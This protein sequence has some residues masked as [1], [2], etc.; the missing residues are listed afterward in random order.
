MNPMSRKKRIK[1]NRGIRKK[2]VRGERAAS[3]RAISSERARSGRA[4]TYE[5]ARSSRAV[6]YERAESGRAISSERTRSGR[7]KTHNTNMGI[8]AGIVASMLILAFLYLFVV[9]S[10]FATK[11]SLTK[12]DL[13]SPLD[14]G[15]GHVNWVLNEIGIYKLHPYLLFGELPVIEFVITDQSKTFTTT[16]TNNYPTT[17]AG[18]TTNPDTRFSMTSADFATL[19]ASTD[20]LAKTREMI[21]S[22]L[23]KVEVVSKNEFALAVKGYKSIYDALSD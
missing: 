16:V 21:K 8:V 15:S 10:T 11:P 13:A 12:S 3:S 20:V 23:L 17:V 22:G 5:R 7:E 6:G 4:V 9:T 1:V 18:Y 19:Y 14:I 2:A